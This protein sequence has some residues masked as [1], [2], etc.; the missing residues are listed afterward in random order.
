M[1]NTSTNRLKVVC[2]CDPCIASVTHDSAGSHHAQL[3]PG[4]DKARRTGGSSQ[5]SAPEKREGL[6]DV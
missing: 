2:F 1:Y 4:P 5:C 6:L 3:M